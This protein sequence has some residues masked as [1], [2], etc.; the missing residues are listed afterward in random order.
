MIGD[1]PIIAEVQCLVGDFSPS[2][3]SK[4]PPRRATD[5]FPI[6]RLLLICAVLEKRLKLSLYGRDVYLNVV[7]GLRISEPSSDLAVAVAVVSS[8]V[9]LK[10]LPGVALIG[11]IGLNGEIRGGRK[12]DQRV[13]EA[14]NLRF[15]RIFIPVQNKNSMNNRMKDG[16]IDASPDLVPC[17]SLNEVLH[18][19][20]DGDYEKVLA[21]RRNKRKMKANFK[22]EKEPKLTY[23]GNEDRALYGSDESEWMNEPSDLIPYYGNDDDDGMGL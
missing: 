22:N 12:L 14:R 7:G 13:A 11:E 19:A 15:N 17:H 9:G 5:G 16:Y 1:R 20:L 21:S 2:I 3:A 10:V 8:L 4:V 18:A 23:V 6:Q